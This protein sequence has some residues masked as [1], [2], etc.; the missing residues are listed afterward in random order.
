MILY[1]STA[2][3]KTDVMEFLS[4]FQIIKIRYFAYI[5]III[6]MLNIFY[7]ESGFKFNFVLMYWATGFP[8]VLFQ[9]VKVVK[10]SPIYHEK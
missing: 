4:T 3:A 8:L 7:H 6:L 2:V 1:L 5:F 9:A 10:L